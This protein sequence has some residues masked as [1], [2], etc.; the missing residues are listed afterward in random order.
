MVFLLLITPFVYSVQC[1]L[2][3]DIV[4][5][6][7]E[8]YGIGDSIQLE[9]RLNLV[10]GDEAGK[11]VTLFLKQGNTT[12]LQQK[13]EFTND[14]GVA[15]FNLQ[16]IQKSGTYTFLAISED[17][18]DIKN[19]EI[20]PKVDLRMDIPTINFINQDIKI[21]LRVTDVESGAVLIADTLVANVK[22]GEESLAYT[23]TGTTITIPK[24]V[25]NK[26]GTIMVNATAKK[27]GYLGDTEIGTVVVQN[28]ITDLKL[29]ID[30]E[31]EVSF[32]TEGIKT[33]NRQ[34]NIKVT[35]G[36]QVIEI[37]NFD[38]TIKDPSG[39][40]QKLS[41]FRKSDGSYQTTYNFLQEGN[42]YYIFGT[43]Q[44][45][46]E[47]REPIPIDYTVTTI[48]Q[49]IEKLPFQLNWVWFAIAGFFIMVLLLVY[50][51]FIRKPKKRKK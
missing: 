18:Q 23:I 51:I 44:I 2:R 39:E 11:R 13:D 30:G 38:V 4:I 50:F 14:Q 33:G 17:I 19:F 34:I 42:V 5:L 15:L 21:N 7:E 45:F 31:D 9:V 47:G 43:I 25:V 35:E 41:F 12:I 28:P 32:S 36:T 29:T 6:S 37:G 16:P 3:G 40:E 10:S 8:T 48:K 46:G 22:R 20:K 24:N 49:P 26:L 27:S 1:V